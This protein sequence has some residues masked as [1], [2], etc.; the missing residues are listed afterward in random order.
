MLVYRQKSCNHW[1]E[2]SVWLLPGT[3]PQA[4]RMLYYIQ[5]A[6]DFTT[7]SQYYTER[8][9]LNS[10]LIVYTISG[11]GKLLYQKSE[12]CL[13]PGSVFFINCMEYQRYENAGKQP[14]SFL[15][16]HFN[17]CSSLAF[18]EEFIK[19][20]SPVLEG[21]ELARSGLPGVEEELRSILASC[22]DGKFQTQIMTSH[23][24]E[25]IL[26]YLLAASCD[27]RLFAAGACAHIEEMM[28]YLDRHYAEKITLDMLAAL[29]AQNKFTL[30]KEFKKAA[31]VSPTEYLIACRISH[32][33]ALL[34]YSDMT[35]NEIACTVG[36]ENV[37]HFINLFKRSENMTP[38]DFRKFWE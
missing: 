38:G 22:Q 8:E 33:K 2:E 27:K 16:L 6:G 17:G 31:G 36:V 30:Q 3:S 20:G 5:E 14:W 28:K 29:F 15:W 35:V 25:T 10:F 11:T 18:F 1:S 19:S 34:R 37:S 32:A 9:G 12:Y 24:I 7:Y 13:K 23:G 21:E 4:K 26:T